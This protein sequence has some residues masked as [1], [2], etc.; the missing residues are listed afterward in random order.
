MV[1]LTASQKEE[2]LDSLSELKHDLGK[3]LF[4]PLGMLPRDADDSSVREA[5]RVALFETLKSAD[6]CKSAAELWSEFLAEFQIIVE[7][8]E[9]FESLQNAVSDAFAWTTKL[10]APVDRARVE[11]DFRAVGQAIGALLHAVQNES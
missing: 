9:P 8:L 2:L 3:Y 5:I 1:E 10:G 7:A 6:R 11:S 4:L